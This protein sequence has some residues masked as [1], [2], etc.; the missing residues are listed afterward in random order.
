LALGLKLASDPHLGQV[1]YVRVYSGDLEPGTQI[2]DSALGRMERVG[3]LYRMRASE[4]EQIDS[5]RARGIVAV[6]V[7][8]DTSAGA[9]L[10]AL[11]SPIVLESMTFPAPVIEVDIEPKTK[12]DQEKLSIAIQRLADEDPSFQVSSS[13]ETG[14]TV[15]SG[16][17][18]LHL[19]V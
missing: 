15:I 19:E 12:S 16:M 10:G 5:V 4:R 9:P 14:Q 3:K 11:P 7:L 6:M 1:S 18:E 13:E 8:A 17:G 2:L